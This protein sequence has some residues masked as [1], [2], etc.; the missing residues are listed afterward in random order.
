MLITGAAV[1]ALT[2][3]LALTACQ[4][5]PP[6]PAP[7]NPAAQMAV[8]VFTGTSYT[9]PLGSNVTWYT[10]IPTWNGETYAGL[11]ESNYSCVGGYC[12]N[13]TVKIH[14]DYVRADVVAHE[15]GHVVCWARWQD[16]SEA[17]ADRI[18]HEL[19]G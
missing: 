1:V 5:T 13:W 2:A 12:T 16:S 9:E 10:T 4:P 7:S 14:P 15:G 18:M 19:T 11:T 6:P 3:A 8:A 17:C